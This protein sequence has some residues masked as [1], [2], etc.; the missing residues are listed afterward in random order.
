MSKGRSS[1]LVKFSVLVQV[2][3][4]AFLTKTLLSIDVMQ[5]FRPFRSV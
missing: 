2:A 3:L 4:T 1:S 5:I